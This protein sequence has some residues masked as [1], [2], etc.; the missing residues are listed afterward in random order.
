MEE[1]RLRR[2]ARTAAILSRR[3]F[4]TA[5]TSL[6]KLENFK[7]NR[8]SSGKMKLNPRRERRSTATANAIAAASPIAI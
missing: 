5:K 7:T 2:R 3:P 6:K 1:T 4:L 8:P